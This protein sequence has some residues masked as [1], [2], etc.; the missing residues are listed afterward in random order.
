MRRMP[1]IN[2]GTWA[3]SAA[4]DE[5]VNRF[6]RVPFVGGRRQVLSLGAGM[7]TRAFRMATASSQQGDA[8]RL[9]RPFDWST[10]RPTHVMIS[11][12]S[13]VGQGMDPATWA[14]G[15]VAYFEVDLPEVIMNK[16]RAIR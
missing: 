13:L 10:W 7:D 8:L 9:P 15:P 14:P 11:T 4:V 6:L 3:R 12:T 1:L 5:V 16:R 2:R